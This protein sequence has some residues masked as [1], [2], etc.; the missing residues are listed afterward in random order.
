MKPTRI[1]FALGGAAAVA[2]ATVLTA[3]KLRPQPDRDDRWRT[4]TV[5]RS[6]EEIGDPRPLAE[7]GDEIETRMRPAPGDR[8][9]ELSVRIL[10]DSTIT[11]DDVRLAL[12]A[13]KQLVEAGETPA[14]DP[15]PHGRRT[16][17]APGA[18]LDRFVDASK[19]K[20]VL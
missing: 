4:V 1:A 10:P 6:P 2:A 16:L 19:G 13:A 8:G 11:A 7:L 17:S 12:R 9:T 18:L 3:R 15:R 14:V 5:F 20:G